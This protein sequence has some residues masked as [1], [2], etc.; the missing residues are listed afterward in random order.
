[1]AASKMNTHLSRRC[2]TNTQLLDLRTGTGENVA[3]GGHGAWNQEMESIHGCCKKEVA[4][5][6]QTKALWG[7]LLPS[8]LCPVHLGQD[9]AISQQ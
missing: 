9:T 4:G 6:S 7:L 5:I 3:R 8:L 1:M 2:G